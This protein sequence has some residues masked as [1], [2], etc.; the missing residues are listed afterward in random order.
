MEHKYFIAVYTNEVKDYCDDEFFKN[1]FEVSQ[2]EPVF[3]V[4]N[5]IGDV[6]FNKLKNDF[7]Q[8][9]YDNFKVFHLDVPE[10]P[11]QSQFQRN[12]CDSANFLRSVYL[13]QTEL[14]YFLIIES[15]V[16]SPVNL[17]DKFEN[18]IAQLDSQSPDWG[19]VGGLYYW[20]FHNYE[21]DA[22]VT[23]L[24]R[25][26]H[27]LSGCSVY[28]RNLIEKFSFR[29]NPDDLGPFPDAF[30]SYDAGGEFSLWNEHQIKCEHLHNPV[31]GMRVS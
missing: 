3:V 20:G 11:R 12:V 15:D 21:Y 2:G 27:C 24:E 26:L 16:V 18:G 10:H 8:K 29:F 4:D 23:S 31:N 5:T 9:G 25:T 28:R 7:Q 13:N 6:Y 17:L 22:S 30:M 14:P 19:I 1:V